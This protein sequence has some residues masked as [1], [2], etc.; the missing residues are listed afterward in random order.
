MMAGLQR[1]R[2]AKSA[3]NDCPRSGGSD[4]LYR[5][6]TL[7]AAAGL[8]Q[9]ALAG[10][11]YQGNQPDGTVVQGG[12]YSIPWHTLDAGGTV[13]A[14]GGGWA[15]AGTVGQF[16]AT[17]DN[18]LLAGDWSLTGGFWARRFALDDGNELFSDRFESP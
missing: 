1:S 2:T 17:P 11:N 10:A 14:T 8:F 9:A 4:Y 5:G 7:L 16:D 13:S 12:G 6:A 18:A 15:L 3:L